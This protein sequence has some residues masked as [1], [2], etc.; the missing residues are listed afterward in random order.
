MSP[1]GL[2]L[3]VKNKKNTKLA[4]MRGFLKLANMNDED[5]M[6]KLAFAWFICLKKQRKTAPIILSGGG[7]PSSIYRDKIN[8]RKFLF[9][10]AVACRWTL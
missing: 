1:G 7:P 5:V 3:A 9:I 10:E 4:G 6:N 8:K 2:L